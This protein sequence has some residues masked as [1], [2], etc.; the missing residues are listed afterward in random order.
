MIIK[1]G[2]LIDPVK[3][4][5]YV[6]DL[7]ISDGKIAEIA[8]K[9]EAAEGEEVIDAA[10]KCVAPGLID[11]HVHFRDP[12]LTYKEDIHTGA[13][14]SA[15]GGFTTVICMANTKP[16]VDNVDTLKYV[17]DK[18][19]EEK[20]NVLQAGAVSVG[21]QGK[22]LTD[23]ESLLASGAT[24]LTD[25]GIP[26]KDES[27]VRRAMEKAKELDVVLSFHEE[28]PALITNN[29]VN[30][31]KAS[32]FF[33]IGGSPK[34]AEV[35]LVKRDC[36]L[37]KEIG[38]KI[39]IQHISSGDAVELVRQAKAAGASV[40]AEAAPHHFT[41]TEEACIEHGT[42]AKMNPPLRTEED[43]LAI[44]R[45]LQDGTIDMIATDHAPHSADEKAKSITEA[46]SGIIGL[47]TSL[48]LGITRLVRPGHLSLVELIKKMSLNP[49]RI[50][51]LDKGTLN[52]GKDADL[53]IFDVEKCW[54][55][56]TYFSKATN[57]PFTGTELYGEV[58]MTICGGEVVFKK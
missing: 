57:T 52:V 37:A 23:F 9:I 7:K 45:G 48:A 54:T 14:T 30:R 50:Y 58:A 51:G 3:E 16:V 25:D 20:I 15:A 13:L 56:T 40:Y 5:T 36:E 10:G 44:I 6:A 1:N 26:L 41:L 43:R 18:A 35:S 39:N 27:F 38:A 28:D 8:E 32:E 29:G 24:G 34:D 22:E 55:P 21:F 19:K 47:E 42:L 4:M 53:V 2:L 17:L 46:P 49:A 31:G 33:G 11:G 12:G